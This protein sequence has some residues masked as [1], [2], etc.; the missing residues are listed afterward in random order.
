MRFELYSG[1]T[2]TL[3]LSSSDMSMSPCWAFHVLMSPDRPQSWFPALKHLFIGSASSLSFVI[4][5][6]P[7][8]ALE[9]V[10]INFDSGA[11]LA[12]TNSAMA[13]TAS[14]SQRAK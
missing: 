7:C 3:L 1:R 2:R 11:K 5:L 10:Q 12:D 8:P 13:L 14:L 6:S 9:H 4:A